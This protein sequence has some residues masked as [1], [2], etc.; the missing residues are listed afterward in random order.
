ML[1][2]VSFVRGVGSKL[3]SAVAATSVQAHYS[4]A[5]SVTH[6]YP[7][8]RLIFPAKLRWPAAFAPD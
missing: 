2:M 5:T 7:D 3:P 4:E 8:A 6:S 1:P